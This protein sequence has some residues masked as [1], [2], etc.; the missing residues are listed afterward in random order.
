MPLNKKCPLEKN[1]FSWDYAQLL[2]F[3]SNEK[4]SFELLLFKKQMFDRHKNPT[5]W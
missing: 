4:P 3:N 2:E 5:F 1:D